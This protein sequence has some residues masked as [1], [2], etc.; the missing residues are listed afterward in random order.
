MFLLQSEYG[1]TE[2]QVAGKQSIPQQDLWQEY[3]FHRRHHDT[4]SIVPTQ[5]RT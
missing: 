4:Y 3:F 5:T 1:L 2:E